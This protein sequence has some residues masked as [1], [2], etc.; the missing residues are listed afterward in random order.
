MKSV[1]PK[2]HA[3][4]MQGRANSTDKSDLYRAFAR[5]AADWIWEI[6]ANLCYVFH[7][8][9]RESVTGVPAEQLIGRSRID[10]LNESQPESNALS[11]HN[12]LLLQHKC[13]D[14]ILPVTMNNQTSYVN[15]VAEPLFD[16]DGKFMGYRGCGRDVSKRVAL[17]AEL[18]H[19]AAHDDL[20]GVMNRREFERK[21]GVVHNSVQS[22]LQKPH[23]L[24]FIDLDRFKHVNDTGGHH[25]GD[26]LLRELV[27]VIQKHLQ[28]AETVA[29]LG[30]DE[31]GLLL[32]SDA[33]DSL[34]VTEKIIDEISRYQF[35]WEDL[36][37]QVGA[38]IG[39]AE[40][41]KD[42]E[43]VDSLMVKADNAC[44]SA[45]HN[46]RN[47]S[48]ISVESAN[49][50]IDDSGRFNVVKRALKNSQ[51]KLLMQ[52]IISLAEVEYFK[53]Y[54]LLVR[55]QCENGELLE[56]NSFMPIARRFSL[57]QELDYWVVEN[58]LRSLESS[59]AQNID[60]AYS[61]NLSASTL[62][63]SDALDRIAEIFLNYTIPSK[64]VCFDIT[65]TYAFRNI[66]AVSSFID[67]MKVSG[68]EFALDDFGKGLSSFSYL[69]QLPI[70]YLKIDGELIRK[71]STDATV[72]CIVDSFHLLAQKLGIRTVAESVEDS[73]TIDCV[74]EIGIDY[75]QG[76]GVAKL[77][78][79]DT[80]P[81]V[82]YSPQRD[83]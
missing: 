8:G 11:E 70:D 19:L 24:C 81:I 51:Y 67:K 63:N 55:L 71:L 78:E 17:E 74:R 83:P 64:R 26:Q 21:L 18:A 61:I 65:E 1:K 49:I 14:L 7:D 10:V 69:Q 53:R 45:K 3:R 60:I 33:Q 50:D 79:L 43:S 38:S 30:G 54:E 6:D 58:A 25:A 77:T 34:I 5:L 44:Y 23:S 73:A 56:P 57:L 72:E 46:G 4:P 82:N 15:V 9:R 68:V 62:A 41:T 16:N 59:H 80:S 75:M 32:Q 40:I 20:T 36:T 35:K 52:P 48:H 31:F 13:I 27:A 28:P 42:C 12:Q 47:Q 22:G 76:F 2:K 37:F 29:R 66:T 39:I